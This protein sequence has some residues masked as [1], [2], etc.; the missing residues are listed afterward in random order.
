VGIVVVFIKRVIACNGIFDVLAKQH[1]FVC[2]CNRPIGANENRD[3]L[4]RVILLSFSV[5]REAKTSLGGLH[6]GKVAKLTRGFQ[7]T[8]Q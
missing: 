3:V 8:D 4:A 7:F 5:Q 2:M 6:A 1:Q